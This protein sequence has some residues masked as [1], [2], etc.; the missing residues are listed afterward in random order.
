[1]TAPATAPAAGVA[2]VSLG[3]GGSGAVVFS[4]A[5]ADCEGVNDC[6]GVADFGG[7]VAEAVP[8]GESD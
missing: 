2:A 7:G 3:G 6:D 8:V 4:V 5:E 1:M